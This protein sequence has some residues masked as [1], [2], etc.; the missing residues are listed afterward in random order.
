MLAGLTL[1]ILTGISMAIH[2]V[3]TI[4]KA[5]LSVNLFMR[6]FKYGWLVRSAHVNGASLI[7]C[8]LYAHIFK[9]VYYRSYLDNRKVVWLVGSA[10][11]ILMMCI[12][13]MGYVLP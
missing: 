9:A 2:Y 13:F 3:P 6:K 12:S 4:D 8:A 11:Y 1:Q 10:I 5:F 7:F